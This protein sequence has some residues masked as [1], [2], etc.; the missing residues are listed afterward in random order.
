MAIS[1][2]IR[3]IIPIR[4]TIY[5]IHIQYSL[6]TFIYSVALAIYIVY[7]LYQTLYTFDIRCTH[8]PK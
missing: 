5:P 3:C 1:Y 7:S 2:I 6:Y 8:L 4:A